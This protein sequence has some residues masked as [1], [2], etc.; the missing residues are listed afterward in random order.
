MFILQRKL[1]SHIHRLGDVYLP[2]LM[3]KDQLRKLF[4]MDGEFLRILF[5]RYEDPQRL[6]G[7]SRMIEKGIGVILIT[8]TVVTTCA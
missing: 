5:G 1:L 7:N 2:H 6:G 4:W 3:E 8:V